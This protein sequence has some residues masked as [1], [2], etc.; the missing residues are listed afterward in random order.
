M[1]RL[2]Y[3]AL[4]LYVFT[5]PWEDAVLIPGLGTISRLAGL[6]ALAVGFGYL[7]FSGSMKLHRLHV[8]AIGFVLLSAASFFWSIDDSE[9]ISRTF[10]YALLFGFFWLLYN[11]LDSPK[12]IYGI[13]GAYVLGAYVGALDTLRNY[14]SNKATLY[15]R[16]AATGFDPNDLSFV[17]VL[18]IP[19]AWYL[20]LKLEKSSWVWVYRL[21]PLVALAAIFLTG[22]RAGLIGASLALMFVFLTIAQA[23]W[24]I[25]ALITVFSL[26]VLWMIPVIIPPE[27]ISRLATLGEELSSGT[28]N[29]RADIWAV[30][31]QVF[32][33]HP[34][35][36]VGSGGY[37]TAMIPELRDWK[38]PHNVFLSIAVD[39]GIV[40]LTLFLI[41]YVGALA[42]ALQMPYVERTLWVI[43]LGI[44]LLTFLSL[45]WEWRKQTWFVLGMILAHREVLRGRVEAVWQKTLSYS[46]RA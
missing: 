36:G 14:L 23:N 17:L 45:N 43:M 28:L 8:V 19:L 3:W 38:A 1:H 42:S 33:D 21:Y 2:A 9:T 35:L 6:L 15:S 4:L 5:V 34:I 24:R 20:N 7:L 27:T 22:S 29:D 18:A 13:M 44:L 40:G 30:G 10:Q 41:L 39:L 25:R 37:G 12:L 31:Y 11:V 32:A 46:Q 16:Y 26:V